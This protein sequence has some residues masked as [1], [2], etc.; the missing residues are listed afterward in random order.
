MKEYQVFQSSNIKGP[1]AHCFLQTISAIEGL[2][3][4]FGY[5]TAWTAQCTCGSKFRTI[6]TPDAAGYEWVR[7]LP[8]LYSYE[9]CESRQVYKADV[10]LDD[11]ITY[12]RGTEMFAPM[13]IWNWED[14]VQPT[15]FN[16]IGNF[17]DVM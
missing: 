7:V 15:I 2:L 6:Q 1:H 14:G 12:W 9:T 8:D 5:L 10:S 3:N 4:E 11:A 13:K 16:T 17:S